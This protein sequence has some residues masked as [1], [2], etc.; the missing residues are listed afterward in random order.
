MVVR[1]GFRN[2]ADTVRL[3]ELAGGALKRTRPKVVSVWPESSTR[4]FV[5]EDVAA[6]RYLGQPAMPALPVTMDVQ[7][8][9]ED[10]IYAIETDGAGVETGAQARTLACGPAT[11]R[12]R[13]NSGWTDR[14]PGVG[15]VAVAAAGR[16]RW[17]CGFVALG[18]ALYTADGPSGG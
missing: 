16:R 13:R 1:Q 7:V 2:A 5:V 18:R 12:G 6:R 10:A 17:P 8:V 4:T 15:D 14:T 11:P 3:Y 9:N